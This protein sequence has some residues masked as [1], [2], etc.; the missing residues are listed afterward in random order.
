MAVTL[1]TNPSPEAF[2]Y[3][4][5]RQMFGDFVTGLDDARASF[6][7]AGKSGDYVIEVNP[8]KIRVDANGDGASDERREPRRGCLAGLSRH[9]RWIDPGTHRAGHTEIRVRR[10]RPRRRVLVG[11]LYQVIAAQADFLLAHDFSEF[12]NAVFH[13]F[14]PKAGFP[15]QDYAAPAAS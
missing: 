7:I 3:D 8:L 6:D 1:P 12:V 14:F 2:N 9:D 13:R 11:G 5:V 15:M 10:V 4:G